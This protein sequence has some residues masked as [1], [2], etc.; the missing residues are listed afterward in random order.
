MLLVLP[1]RDSFFSATCA[2]VFASHVP[3]G[4]YRK[5]KCQKELSFHCIPNN[6]TTRKEWCELIGKEISSDQM[7][8]AGIRDCE[9]HFLPTR[10][11]IHGRLGDTPLREGVLI[12]SRP[13]APCKKQTAPR[14]RDRNL[15]QQTCSSAAVKNKS[16][17]AEMAKRG[18]G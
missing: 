9:T 10:Y 7:M 5:K 12:V 3:T 13:V 4:P 16:L 14:T 8:S 6:E 1:S 15:Y 17:A 11:G 18:R 2:H